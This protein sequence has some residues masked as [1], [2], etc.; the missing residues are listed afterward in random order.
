MVAN[1][2]LG[3]V[4]ST[5]EDVLE[6]SVGS[7]MEKSGLINLDLKAR[8]KIVIQ[9]RCKKFATKL[10]EQSARRT[11]SCFLSLDQDHIDE[12]AAT[13]PLTNTNPSI[14]TSSSSS[15]STSRFFSS[16]S[17]LSSSNSK[18]ITS[19]TFVFSR[20]RGKSTKKPHIR[21]VSGRIVKSSAKGRR[22]WK[23][24]EQSPSVSQQVLKRSVHP[25]VI[26]PDSSYS[27]E[28]SS[29]SLSMDSSA[30]PTSPA[31]S[32]SS[33]SSPVETPL[34]APP[35]AEVYKNCP[36][37]KGGRPECQRCCLLKLADRFCTLVE[38]RCQKM[39]IASS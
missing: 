20:K 26:P 31:T 23:G 13:T 24:L 21:I 36:C 17:T 25:Q 6:M 1:L 10:K 27:F 4:L 32:S 2:K 30:S 22:S 38:T 28:S 19:D 16:S 35:Y 12:D 7:L 37:T 29:S 15:P 3:Q 5:N 8:D 34:P 33:V 11:L 18:Q 9:P 39:G 14:S